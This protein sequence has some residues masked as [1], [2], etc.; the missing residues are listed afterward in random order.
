MCDSTV[1]TDKNTGLFRKPDANDKPQIH[2]N[3][4]GEEKAFSAEEIS[5]M[6]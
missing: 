1:Q 3:Y 5:S 2:V 4:K 6:Y